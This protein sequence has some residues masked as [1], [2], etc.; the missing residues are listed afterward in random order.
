MCGIFGHYVFGKQINRKEVLEILFNGLRR[1]EYRGYDS[2]GLSIESQPF[3]PS[4]S[5]IVGPA[6]IIVKAKGNIPALEA[7]LDAAAL[8][9]SVEF[10]SHVGT[11]SYALRPSAV[12]GRIRLVL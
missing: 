9:V 11:R 4:D 7:E 5:D 12:E 10:R 6:P 8:D 1:L 2:A 3:Q